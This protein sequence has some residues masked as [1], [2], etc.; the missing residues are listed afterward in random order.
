MK[1]TNNHDLPEPLYRTICWAVE[2]YEG[3]KA[4]DIVQTRRLS[5]TTLI[6]PPRLTMLRAVHEEDLE[7]DASSLLYMVTGIAFHFMMAEVGWTA[8]GDAVIEERLARNYK[9]WVITG[10]FDVF[11]RTIL[12]DWKWTSIWSVV[13][14]KFEWDAQLNLYYWLARSHGM[15]PEKLE[16]WALLRDW[17]HGKHMKDKRV[18][19]IPF[20]R[21]ERALWDDGVTES[22]IDARIGLYEEAVSIVQTTGNPN[23]VPVCSDEEKWMRKGVPARCREYCDV[24]RFCSFGMHQ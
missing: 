14:P 18:P 8:S 17:S 24:A 22:Y 20:A 10:Q 2:R 6:N 21:I 1:I 5:V 7:V 4:K 15:K 11:A 3:P 19:E 13:T 9:G 16:T 12:S 23:I